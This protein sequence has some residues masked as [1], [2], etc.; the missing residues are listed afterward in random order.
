MK[1]VAVR[2][3]LLV[4]AL[5]KEQWDTTSPISKVVQIVV[6]MFL[7]IVLQFSLRGRI[8]HNWQ[9]TS[10]CNISLFLHSPFCRAEGLCQHAAIQG[11]EGCLEI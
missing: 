2:Q 7:N 8:R 1:F 5:I 6:I 4:I 3:V 10:N 9:D 11:E